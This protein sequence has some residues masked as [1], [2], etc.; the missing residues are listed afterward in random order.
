MQ[1]VGM[2]RPTCPT[3]WSHVNHL[4][5]SG[6]LSRACQ[7]AGGCGRGGLL[8]VQF[9]SSLSRNRHTMRKASDSRWQLSQKSRCPAPVRTCMRINP[10]ISIQGAHALLQKG[11]QFMKGGRSPGAGEKS[12]DEN[13]LCSKENPQGKHRLNA[14]F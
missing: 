5:W 11:A 9:S 14:W 1:K 4:S 8:L 3:H 2:K 7:A 12:A 6:C 13:G 10:A